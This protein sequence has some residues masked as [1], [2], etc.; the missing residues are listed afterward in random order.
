MQAIQNELP[1]HI[2]RGGLPQRLLDQGLEVGIAELSRRE[3][4]LLLIASE[5]SQAQV[6]KTVRAPTALRGQMLYIQRHI[7]G[8]AVDT[9]PTP[10]LQ[11]IF[12]HFIALQLTLLVFHARDI[13]VLE[14][15]RI[16]FYVLQVYAGDRDPLGVPLHPGED[17]P[18]T[19]PHT[20]RQPPFRATAVV[21][22]GR[23]ITQVSR[24]PP[25]AIGRPF[26]HTVRHQAPLML[27]LAGVQHNVDGT[28]RRL[29]LANDHHPSGGRPWINLQ[30]DRLE[31]A[32]LQQA[33]F[34]ADRERA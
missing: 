21:E 34:Q 25:S 3:L 24:P 23:S 8:S 11:Q 4:A 7:L 1:S 27:Y 20:G 16:E 31:D 32:I 15:L 5:A 12:P 18:Y 9:S 28:F 19:A 22:P 26:P 14:L 2:H 30:Y 10:L 33:V 6:A 29:L 17:V 13:W